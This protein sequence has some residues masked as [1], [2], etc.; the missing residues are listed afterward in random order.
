[1]ENFPSR[2]YQPRQPLY[3]AQGRSTGPLPPA[4]AT[5]FQTIDDFEFYRVGTSS[6]RLSVNTIERNPYISVS[7]W[8]LNTAQAAWFPS[9]KQ[10]FLPKT[11]RFGFWNRLI[12]RIKLFN[13]FLSQTHPV[14][15]TIK[16]GFNHIFEFF[17]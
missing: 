17:L 15:Q 10:I 8:W 4:P 7:H 14:C 11:A 1:M 9:R 16:I 2:S 13:Q 5:D 6:S 3:G 12:A